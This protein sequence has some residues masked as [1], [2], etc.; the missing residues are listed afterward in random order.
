MS[1]QL[2]RPAAGLLSLTAAFALGGCWSADPEPEPTRGADEAVEQESEPAAEEP[3]EV[4][5]PPPPAT[6]GTAPPPETTQTTTP[7]TMPTTS[8]AP[9]PSSLAPPGQGP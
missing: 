7:T 8:T 3:V 9:D 5:E 1:A 4:E 6:T 2:W